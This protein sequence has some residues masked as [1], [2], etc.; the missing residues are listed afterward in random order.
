MKTYFENGRARAQSEI[1]SKNKEI[2]AVLS[3]YEKM[4][5]KLG[6]LINQT[7]EEFVRIESKNIKTKKR[8]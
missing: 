1:M 7:I 8:F 6:S 2:N 3:H 4:R 5:E